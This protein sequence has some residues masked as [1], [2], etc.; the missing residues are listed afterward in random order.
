MPN[1]ER[2]ADSG[3][4]LHD[5]LADSQ[6]AARHKKPREPNRESVALHR[7]SKLLI[8]DSDSV[9]QELVNTAVEFCAAD[10]AGISLEEPDGKCFRW[11]AIAGRFSPYLNGQAPRDYSPCGVC[12]DSGRPQL[13]QISQPYFDLLGVTSE[14]IYDGILIPWT[15][16][17]LRGTLWAVS[18]SLQE[19]FDMEDYYFLSGLADFASIVLRQQQYQKMLRDLEGD[20]AAAEMAHKLAHEINNP[21]QSLTNTIFL[22]RHG[23]GDT[24]RY[25]DQAEEKLSQLSKLVAGVLGDAIL[26]KT[27]TEVIRLEPRGKRMQPKAPG[28]DSD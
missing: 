22:A 27:R 12:L 10:S 5:L 19:T 8:E 26:P 11:I 28:K 17:F 18:H 14:P 7:L 21:L 13:F 3:M 23:M 15:N 1:K 6:F 9:L 4:Y 16:E 2:Q 20:R 25:L 24:Q